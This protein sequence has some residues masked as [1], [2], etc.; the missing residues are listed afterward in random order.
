MVSNVAKELCC[1]DDRSFGLMAESRMPL[2]E[3]CESLM[4]Q[5][6]VKD[7]QIALLVHL[8]ALL[9]EVDEQG[10]VPLS[11]LRNQEMMLAIGYSPRE[12]KPP[13]S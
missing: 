13:I 10:V 12:S 4:R 1:G 9:G 5:L 3:L 11:L 8:A 6:E 2:S 7:E